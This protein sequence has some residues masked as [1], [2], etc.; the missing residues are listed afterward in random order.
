MLDLQGLAR[1]GSF[2]LLAG[3]PTVTRVYTLT[4][5]H[6]VY[7]RLFRALHALG[8]SDYPG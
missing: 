4:A 3:S 1:A 5:L 7:T 6:P 2:P 8:W